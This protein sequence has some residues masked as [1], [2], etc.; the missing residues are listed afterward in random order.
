[1]KT[2]LISR[3]RATTYQLF[4]FWL[5]YSYR[6]MSPL[7]SHEFPS[8]KKDQATVEKCREQRG[9]TKGSIKNFAKS[10]NEHK[11]NTQNVW[12]K[13]F[14][15]IVCD[16]MLTVCLWCVF[17]VDWLLFMMAPPCWAKIPLIHSINIFRFIFQCCKI[18][19]Y[20]VYDFFYAFNSL[21]FLSVGGE[22]DIFF[23]WPP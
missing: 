18:I 20:K 6:V 1:M 9:K 10:T 11:L 23:L 7:V 16:N 4:F 13:K 14:S 2:Y 19:S 22:R 17:C 15:H 5:L 3:T 21:A 8:E 12:K